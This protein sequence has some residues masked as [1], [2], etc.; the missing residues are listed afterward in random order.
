M[1]LPSDESLRLLMAQI[2]LTGGPG[3]NMLGIPSDSEISNWDLRNAEVTEWWK[4]FTGEALEAR[5]TPSRRADAS[6]Y[7]AF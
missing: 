7:R 6:G 3:N 2:V 1:W 4:W 5:D